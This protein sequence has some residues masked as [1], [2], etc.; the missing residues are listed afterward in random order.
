MLLSLRRFPEN[1]AY[2]AFLRKREFS[3]S[4][5]DVDPRMHGGGRRRRLSSLWLGL[6]RMVTPR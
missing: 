3:S 5:P 1:H 6:G 4:R 2:R